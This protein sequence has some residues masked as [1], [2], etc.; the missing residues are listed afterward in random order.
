MTT[1][2]WDD[3]RLDR[4]AAIVESNA[5]AIEAISNDVA[6]NRADIASTRASVDALAQT[7]IE[8]TIRTETRI[9]SNEARL[10]RLDDAVIGIERLLQELLRRELR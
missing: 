3:Q 9:N 8:F 10:D 6:A 4:L 2:R 5:R 7:I 1:D